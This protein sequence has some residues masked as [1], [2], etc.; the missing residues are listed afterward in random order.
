MYEKGWFMQFVE[1]V[2]ILVLLMIANGTPVI[3]KRLMGDRFAY[4]LDAGAGF[5]D[6]RPVFGPSKTL[7]GLVSSLLATT[8]V[9]PALGLDWRIGPVVAIA[10]MAGDLLSS[11]CKRRIGMASGSMALGIDQIP[12]SLLPFLAVRNEF[13]L[14]VTDIT[15]GVAIFFVGEL[16]IS[17]ILYRFGLRERPY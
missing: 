10:A 16:V 15:A 13:D 12:E 2:K 7:R 14:S 8:L 9:A 17:R 4:P 3:L 11:F 6:G 1:L 5:P